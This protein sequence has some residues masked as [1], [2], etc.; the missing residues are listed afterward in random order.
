MDAS[1]KGVTM[2]AVTGVAYSTVPVPKLFQD[3]LPLLL[4][5]IHDLFSRNCLSSWHAYCHQPD[6]VS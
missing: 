6:P 2:G 4:M 1:I 5:M 3:A